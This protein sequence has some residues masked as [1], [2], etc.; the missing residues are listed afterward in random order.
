MAI[1][2]VPTIEIEGEQ[3][4]ATAA[5]LEV[6][7]V[8]A[9]GFEIEW[10]RGDYHDSD[11]SPASLKLTLLDA[12]GEWAARIRDRRA[13]G[14]RIQISWRGQPAT[15]GGVATS[16]VIMFRG[17]IQEAAARPL[18]RRTTDG[19]RVWEVSLECADRTADYGNAVLPD[20]EAEVN[21]STAIFHANRIRNLGLAA[22][23]EIDEVYFW[24]GYVDSWLGPQDL[25]GVSALDMMTEFYQSMGN[26][27][28]AYDP[29]ENVVRQAIRLS[30]PY[31][32]HLGSFDDALGAV[33]P[34]PSD[35]EVDEVTY[36]GVALGADTLIGDPEIMADPAT[37]IN[38]LECSWE[39]QGNNYD[40]WTTVI[41]FAAPG[42]AR[43]VMSWDSLFEDGRVIDPTMDNV[44]DRV[45]QEGSR[46][47]HPEIETLPRHEF[48]TERLA[49]WI[50]QTWENT[51][52]A[53][54]A[55]SLPYHWLMSGESNYPPVVA[56]IGGTTR[57][58]PIDG[59]TV[60]F[61]VHWVHNQSPPPRPVTWRGI[62]QVSMS[63]VSPSVPW[64]WQLLG[65]PMPDP[66]PVGE[67]APDRYMTWGAPAAGAGY[68]FAPSVTW[69][70]LK[71]VADDEAQIQ[72][73]LN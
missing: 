18:E 60:T 22:G 47:R 59:W 66:I 35:I 23:S 50:L 53:F 12:V 8:A 10:G 36:P 70:D 32:V 13:I 24:P 49:R 3:V 44:L 30:Q 40:S 39:D 69:A 55:G 57:Y 21:R 6:A 1:K 11:T 15:P 19:R 41:D 67:P 2:V 48:T 33:L 28:W 63:S 34:V 51:R 14:R 46:P 42:D 26:D 29:D 62:E 7:P 4:A 17:R 43:R 37:E 54:I 73:H 71:H 56:P 5:A 45:Q 38:R 68:R 58:D 9:H 20:E 61:R 25:K 72:D 52:P 65:L 16:P 27:S 64:W 31:S